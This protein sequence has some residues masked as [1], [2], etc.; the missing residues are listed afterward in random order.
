MAKL[1][2]RDLEILRTLAR[3]HFASSAELNAA[4]FSSESAGHRRL[5][6][7]AD[8]DLVKRHIKGIPPRLAYFAWRLTARGV[9]SVLDEFTEEAIPE[10]LDDRLANQSLVD[11]EHREAITRVYLAL[12][13]GDQSERLK[14]PSWQAVQQWIAAV[15]QRTGQL[16]WHPDGTVVL[17]YRD[18][19]QDH[20][21]VPDVTITSSAKR[22][23]LY[24][25][26]DRSNKPLSRIKEN[27]ER[28]D[29][30]IRQAHGTLHA[31]GNEPWVVYLVRSKAR[32]E[33]VAKLAKAV[34]R[35]RWAVLTS[36]QEATQWL[37][38]RLLGEQR[39]EPPELTATETDTLLTAA[40][41]LVRSSSDLLERNPNAFRSLDQDDPD[42]VARW[43]RDLRAVHE[44]LQGS[45][46]A[47]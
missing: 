13:C 16:H 12:V 44:I 14:E 42:K 32:R 46:H 11:I 8:L 26:L 24:V 27:L 4:F 20:R 1:E 10:G 41:E 5:K 6:K 33:H 18:L 7:L 19:G 22:L 45:K 23:R 43:K 2:I 17:R 34:L 30:Y 21:V 28:Y 47:G 37:A 29:G 39:A 31:D 36:G 40:H 15:R 35:C 9:G 3:V 38:A 25:E